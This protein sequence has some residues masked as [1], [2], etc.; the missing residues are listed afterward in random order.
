MKYGGSIGDFALTALAI[1]LHVVVFARMNVCVNNTRLE[2]DEFHDV[3]FS[4]GRP[5][6]LAIVGAQGPNCRPCATPS[7]ELGSHLNSSIGPSRLA[8][9]SKAGRGVVCKFESSA[10]ALRIF[11]C[12]VVVGILEFFIPGLND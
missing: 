9:R 6:Y 10:K 7:R 2:A 1:F 5:T 8:A 12:G 4:A 11:C 3:D